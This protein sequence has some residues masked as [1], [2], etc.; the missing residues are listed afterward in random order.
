VNIVSRE[1]FSQRHFAAAVPRKS[2]V[3]P[4]GRSFLRTGGAKAPSANNS[5]AQADA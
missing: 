1:T 2:R 4:G 3:L 5:A